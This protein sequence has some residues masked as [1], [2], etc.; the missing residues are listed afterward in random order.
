MVIKNEKLSNADCIF[1]LIRYLNDRFFW[2]RNDKFVTVHSKCTKT[3]CQPHCTLQLMCVKIA[4]CSSELSFTFLCAGSS[5]Q[6]ASWQF[7]SCIHPSFVNFAFH[8]TPQTKFYWSWVWR[9]KQMYLSNHS[10]LDTC[11]YEMFS[12]SAWSCYCLNNSV[13]C[14]QWTYYW[15]E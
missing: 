4:C 3:H 14:D 7:V 9:F 2:Y 8:P 6:N 13:L 12:H 11:T 15:P 10:E 1:I 5:I